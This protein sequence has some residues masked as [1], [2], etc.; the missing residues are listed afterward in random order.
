MK[1][2]SAVQSSESIPKETVRSITTEP[3]TEAESSLEFEEIPWEDGKEQGAVLLAPNEE[4][5]AGI[6][7]QI[8][9]AMQ[10]VSHLPQ[11]HK[12]RYIKQ[13]DWLGLLLDANQLQRINLYFELFKAIGVRSNRIEWSNLFNITHK[14]V[15]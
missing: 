8:T 1:A 14:L 13:G 12:S 9:E 15:V 3:T 11:R 6:Q 7:K 4:A 10:S 5:I 2:A